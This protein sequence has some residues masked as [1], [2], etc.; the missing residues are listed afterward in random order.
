MAMTVRVPM[1]V[2]RHSRP[3]HQK[4]F[5]MMKSECFMVRLYPW[6]Y[7]PDNKSSLCHRFEIWCMLSMPDAVPLCHAQKVDE[8]HARTAH[9]ENH[10]E[11]EEMG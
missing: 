2:H 4:L 6:D 5:P 7:L 9:P 11:G 10:G 3:P 1:S 8:S